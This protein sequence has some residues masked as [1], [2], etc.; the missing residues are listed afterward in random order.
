MRESELSRGWTALDHLYDSDATRL[1]P[2]GQSLVQQRPTACIES[3]SISGLGSLPP[4]SPVQSAA[5]AL[6]PNLF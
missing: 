5:L 3:L 6:H 4:G 1:R 2:P